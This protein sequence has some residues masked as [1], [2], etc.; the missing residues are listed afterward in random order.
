MNTPYECYQFTKQAKNKTH[1]TLVIELTLHSDFFSIAWVNTNLSPVHWLQ[2]ELLTKKNSSIK[3]YVDQS[4]ESNL[5]TQR[6]C[7]ASKPRVNN[8]KNT[9]NMLW[10]TNRSPAGFIVPWNAKVVTDSCG[11]DKSDNTCKCS[12]YVQLRNSTAAKGTVKNAV[13]C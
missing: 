3:V 5:I 2:T 12:K 13:Y 4:F 7:K 11:K 1:S 10:V 9:T 6:I 8:I